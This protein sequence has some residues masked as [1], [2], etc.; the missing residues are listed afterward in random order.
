MGNDASDNNNTTVCDQVYSLLVKSPIFSHI[1]ELKQQVEGTIILPRDYD[2]YYQARTRPFNIDQQGYPLVIARV[3]SASDV[4]CCVK[5]INIYGGGLK[6]CVA[7]GCHSSHSM[8]SDSFV[9]D[10]YELC[11][12]TL[13]PESKVVLIEGG[14]F[15]QDVDHVLEPFGLAI[16]LGIKPDIGIGGQVLSGGYG[17]LARN[18]GLSVDQLIEAEVVLSDG[19][20][21]IAND[22][23][24]YSDLMWGL[25][26]GGGNFGVVTR[27]VFQ[28][29]S[30]PK[31]CVGGTVSYF[32]PTFQSAKSICREFDNIIQVRRN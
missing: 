5:F 24:E 20:L 21:V 28:A 7:G 19:S 32:A 1:E 9:I 26:G 16:T 4:C 3:K 15:L 22:S 18:Y 6:V 13:D 29:F 10:L 27:F 31:Y 11:K 25:R 2:L 12:V 17:F 30:L 23:N 14:A 8:I